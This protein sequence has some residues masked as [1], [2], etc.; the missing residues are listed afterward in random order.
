VFVRHDSREQGSPLSP[1]SRGNAF[2]DVIAG[3]PD[4]LVA[5]SVHSA[6]LGSPDLAAWRRERGC[7]GIAVC[8]ITTSHCCET[9]ARA[10]S[11]IGFDVLF[12][13]DATHAFDSGGLSA[14][15]LA[16]ATAAN[17]HGEFATVV[18]TADLVG[19]R[20]P[21]AMRTAPVAGT[22]SRSRRQLPLRTPNASLS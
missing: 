3:E 14:D 7:D 9:T 1:D 2:Q 10:G 11:D 19:A 20:P 17:L 21:S 12:V 5:K 18:A 6:F 8:G 22:L 4:L 16:R 15:E 13:L